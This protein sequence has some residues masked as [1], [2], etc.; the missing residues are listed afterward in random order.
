MDLK[1]FETKHIVECPGSNEAADQHRRL[2]DGQF[3]L[4]LKVT[5]RNLSAT[6]NNYTVELHN[7]LQK[8]AELCN[9]AQSMV[10]KMEELCTRMEAASVR[11]D[12]H[13]LNDSN[14]QLFTSY[15]EQHTDQQGNPGQFEYSM[16]P[17]SDL[18][19]DER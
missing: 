12:Q 14:M 2:R 19:K 9:R 4:D 11:P 15:N 8:V 10:E 18:L 6:V 17:F 13:W 1:T 16:T 5:F 7:Q 3:Q